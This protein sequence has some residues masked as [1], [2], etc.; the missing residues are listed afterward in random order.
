[1]KDTELYGRLLG[2]HSPWF[3]RE[4]RYEPAPERI[5]V[6]VDHVAGIELPCP[7]WGR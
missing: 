4:V 6:Y 7:V 2:L 5:A 3:V 1:M